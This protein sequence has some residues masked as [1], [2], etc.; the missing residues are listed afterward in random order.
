[1]ALIGIFTPTADGFTGHIKTLLLDI[2]ATLTPPRDA[3]HD[4]APDYRPA[5]GN[6][7]VGPLKPGLAEYL[8]SVTFWANAD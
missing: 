5:H 6:I 8:R 4:N 3:S 1:M 7:L 2:E